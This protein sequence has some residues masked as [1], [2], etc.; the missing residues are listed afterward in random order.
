[1]RPFTKVPFIH[2]LFIYSMQQEVISRVV[3]SPPFDNIQKRFRTLKQSPDG[4][5][6][7]DE[8]DSIQT[9]LPND[10]IH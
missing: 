5:D 4:A 3:G 8:I 1:M 2:V 6:G 7:V 9:W 10:L